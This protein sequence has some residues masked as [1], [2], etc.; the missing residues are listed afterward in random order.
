MKSIRRHILFRLLPGFVLLWIG[1]C[2]AIYLS[3]WQGLET[4]LDKELRDLL[5]AIP[6][7]EKSGRASLLSIE[8][9]AK[10]DLGIY[11]QIWNRDG[12]RILKSENLGRFDIDQILSFTEEPSYGD[13]L[14]KNGD[15]VRILAISS[16]GGS[17]GGVNIMVA[18][19]WEEANASL[20][21]LL[22]VLV[23]T[24]ALLGLG[25]I[26]LVRFA[27]SAGLRP[28]AAV[29]DQATQFGAEVVGARF[30]TDQ[31]PDELRPIVDKLNELMVR[32]ETS[33]SRERRFSADLAHELR[34]PVAALRSL[35]EV[36]LKW[37]DQAT[38]EN[39]ED[40]LTISEEMKTTI[41]NMLTL[42]RLEK[43]EDQIVC[44]PV[45]IHPMLENCW[46]LFSAGASERGL[47]FQNSL[48]EGLIWET[49]P[50]IL[51]II[52]S[53][54]ISNA[55]EY[56]PEGSEISVSGDDLSLCVENP[57]PHLSE[58]DIPKLF[59][60]LWR[61]DQARTDSSHS[62]LGLFL[63]RTCAEALGLDLSAKLKAGTI[64]FLLQFPSK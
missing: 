37:P 6:F 31:L 40:V 43:A 47:H 23:G 54:L 58:S 62:G 61:H 50:N 33:F 24:G 63:A 15:R 2:S 53:N 38:D 55:V 14:L 1:A 30:P 44:E 10:D 18:R 11:F 3:V 49:D 34:T 41:E 13:Q 64:Q 22:A 8:D 29:G 60:R 21:K 4:G 5:G 59:D 28:L 27:L 12:I 26:L 35:A 51:R 42:A 16:R 46:L 7:S 52:V 19:S 9:I 57:A 25:F 20:R 48:G 32:Q 45:Q 39:Y 56:A 36:A 17:L